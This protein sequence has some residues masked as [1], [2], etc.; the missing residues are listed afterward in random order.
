[1]P[2][3]SP[4]FVGTLCMCAGRNAGIHFYRYRRNAGIHAPS[5]VRVGAAPFLSF[6]KNPRQKIIYGSEKS[7][8]NPA[9]KKTRFLRR[10]KKIRPNDSFF[11]EFDPDD[12]TWCSESEIHRWCKLHTRRCPWFQVTSRTTSDEI[13]ENTEVAVEVF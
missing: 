5:R 8:K 2:G 3:N 9:E 1:M 10:E 4:S 6:R 7:K 13:Q 11:A 12:R